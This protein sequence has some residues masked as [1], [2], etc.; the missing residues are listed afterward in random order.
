MDPQTTDENIASTIRAYGERCAALLER[1]AAAEKEAEFQRNRADEIES[2]IRFITKAYFEAC[3]GPSPCTPAAVAGCLTEYGRAKTRNATLE[4]ENAELKAAIERS[5]K[6][7]LEYHEAMIAA[8]LPRECTT[9]QKVCDWIRE[10]ATV[11]PRSDLP[12]SPLDILGRVAISDADPAVRMEAIKAIAAGRVQEPTIVR[13]PWSAAKSPPDEALVANLESAMAD[14]D[15]YREALLAAGMSTDDPEPI[16]WA[17]ARAQEC[18]DNEA[19]VRMLGITAWVAPVMDPDPVATLVELFQASMPPG[20]MLGANRENPAAVVWSWQTDVCGLGF[21]TPLLALEDAWIRHCA[22]VEAK[23]RKEADRA[24]AD[25]HSTLHRALVTIGM[26]DGC[27]DPQRWADVHLDGWKTMQSSLA[28]LGVNL[29]EVSGSDV[30]NLM[31]LEL[32]CDERCERMGAPVLARTSQHPEL[33]QMV[34]VTIPLGFSRA[35]KESAHAVGFDQRDPVNATV[36]SLIGDTWDLQAMGGTRADAVKWWETLAGR[37][38]AISAVLGISVN[39]DPPI[40]IEHFVSGYSDNIRRTIRGRSAG[41][42][43]GQALAGLAVDI[44]KA[45][46]A[47]RKLGMPEDCKD[48]PRIALASIAKLFPYAR[49]SIQV[50]DLNDITYGGPEVDRG[51]LGHVKVWPSNVMPSS[52][53]D[54]AEVVVIVRA[55]GGLEVTKDRF[56]PTGVHLPGWDAEVTNGGAVANAEHIGEA[57]KRYMGIDLAKDGA[58]DSTVVTFAAVNEDHIGETA[59][60]VSAAIEGPVPAKI[61]GWTGITWTSRKGKAKSFSIPGMVLASHTAEG[62]SGSFTSV[63]IPEGVAH[64]PM[65]LLRRVR[66]GGL[67]TFHMGDLK[68]TGIISGVDRAIRYDRLRIEIAES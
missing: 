56:G 35:R 7:D 4:N 42:S 46:G 25:Q 14:R 45:R 19:I 10:H 8:G 65:D 5:E 23:A 68:R 43:L 13:L 41:V 31:E 33:G 57:G 39:K 22:L 34:T 48:K 16:K 9:M 50:V 55:D 36:D 38:V 52:V 51:E 44:A 17:M 2:D 49:R 20:L 53:Q 26:P 29:Y 32:M 37:W 47:L 59:R 27:K 21:A 62:T 30:A 63:D 6:L 12:C 58:S 61:T 28:S 18:S 60:T 24:A 66:Y 67:L 3:L 1:C 15:S 64:L 54:R 11:P 40:A